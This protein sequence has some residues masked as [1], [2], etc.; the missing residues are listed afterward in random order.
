MGFKMKVN[1]NLEELLIEKVIHRMNE[2]LIDFQVAVIP[3]TPVGKSIKGRTKK[4]KLVRLGLAKIKKG[5]T[6]GRLRQG[7]QLK[8]AEL[9]GNIVIG[10]IF[11]NVHYASHVNFGHR[12][13]YGTG[14]KIPKS[15]AKKYVEG[16]H[17]IE[18]ALNEIN[19]DPK[20][21]K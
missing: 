8:P 14:K 19:I 17:F 5:Y 6:G 2:K 3:K 11:N 10:K 18:K 13:R 1:I 21:Y 4:N 15:G 9:E 12:T 7:W 20:N 16:K